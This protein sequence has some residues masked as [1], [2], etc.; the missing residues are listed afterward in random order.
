MSGGVYWLGVEMAGFWLRDIPN[1]AGCFVP[2]GLY[3]HLGGINHSTTAKCLKNS[4]NE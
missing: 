1:L 2:N 3:L 4:N